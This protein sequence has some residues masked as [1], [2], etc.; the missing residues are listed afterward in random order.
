MPYRVLFIG[1]V[2]IFGFIG[3]KAQQTNRGGDLPKRLSHA[4]RFAAPQMLAGQ[5]EQEAT[6]RL[7]KNPNDAAALHDR[8]IARI[9]LERFAEAAEDLRRAVSLAA[10]NADY[11]ANYGY[12][13]ARLG[14]VEEAI[15]TERAALALDDKNFAAHYYLG[16]MLLKIGG[17]K[18]IDEAL[19]HLR[20]ALE[21]NPLRDEIRFDLISIY[22]QKGDFA[23]A[24][25]QLAIL[26]NARMTD[27][28]VPYIRGLLLT[29]RGDL[30]EAIPNFQDALR[31]NET[32]KGA[33][34]DLGLT[35]LKLKQWM[36][37]AE[38]FSA[39]SK[40]E[41]DSVEAAYFYGLALFNLGK[42]GEAER[43][44]RRA[45][46]KNAGFG[47]ALTLLGIILAS[48][49]GSN[50]EAKDALMQSVALDAKNFDGFFY[51][52]RVLYAAKDFA[53]AIESLKRAVELQPKHAEARFFL[54][55]A[56]ESAGDSDGA[57]LQYQELVNID[58][59]SAYG[60]IGLG[61]LLVKQ[62]KLDEAIVAL[63]RANEL[64]PQNFEARWALGRAYMLK[65]NFAEAAASLQKAV[66][67]EPR[68]SDAHYQLGLAFR[69]LGK[70]AEAAREFKIVEQI[71]REFR[72][73]AVP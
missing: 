60:Q 38:I 61:A 27:A 6:A 8:A 55:T 64:N 31:K 7:G 65:E 34:L 32:L 51:L 44:V 35:H 5:K 66:E 50:E 56:L 16:R 1:I 39:L 40:R 24:S 41:P 10:K 2:I 43:E 54:G 48:K 18:N 71:N 28:R 68:R 47:E 73:T 13:L 45:L 36:E 4:E 14:K 23:E 33:W 72:T 3:L 67:L 26:E 25:A 15:K 49:G 9:Q 63:K 70:T 42:I 12:V 62:N 21:I 29:D 46:K 53:G 57:L 58:S 20:R 30:K 37:A 59:N 52:G 17:Q 19:T 11:Q 69:R 22:R